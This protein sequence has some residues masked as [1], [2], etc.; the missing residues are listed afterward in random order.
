[1]TAHLLALTIGPVQEFISAARRTRDLWFGS[2]L[3]SEI[4][5]A[6]AKAV[7]GEGGALIFPA[8]LSDGELNPDSELNVANVIVSELRAGL[9]PVAVAQTAKNAAHER[10]RSFA[11]PVFETHQAFI[12]PDIWRDQVDDVIE[13]YAAWVHRSP[14]GYQVDRGRLMRLLAGR[15]RCRDFLPAKGRAGVPKSSLDGLRETV[16]RPPERWPKGSRYRPRLQQ[17]EQLDVVAMVKRTWTPSTGSP[18][19][20]SVGRVAADPWLRG[21]GP[22]RLQP[23]LEA[24]EAL[25]NNVLHA[26]DISAERGHDHYGSFPFEGTAVYGSRHR[27]LQQEAGL[28]SRD[29][30]PLA[31]AVSLLTRDFGEPSPYLAVLVADGDRIGRALSHLDSAEKHRSFSQAL[32]TFARQARDVVHQHRGILVYAG[33]DD[34][35]AV[36]PADQCLACAHGLHNSFG[37][38]LKPAGVAKA[39]LCVGVAIAHFMEP[40]EDLLEYGRAAEKHAKEPRVEDGKQEA[41]NALAV[42]VIKRG[43]GPVAIRSNWHLDPNKRLQLQTLA[44]WIAVRAVSGRV[45]YDLR[46]IAVVYDTWPAE[47]V[48]AAIQRDTLATLQRKQP[49]GESRMREVGEFI[50]ARVKG[51]DS[52][53]R[54][55]D[56]LLVARQI[57]VAIGQAESRATVGED[58]A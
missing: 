50:R 6:T 11:D 22:E 31:R 5:K 48:E 58:I 49:L 30:A 28:S 57:A 21:V 37:N 53:R 1:M 44:E 55:S 40:L 24:S 43:G 41:R 8:P 56:E 27:A 32:A 51:A 45:A 23:V 42:H 15:K 18:Q 7:L 39:T 36:I 17:G 26:L 3:L 33:G 52:L 2:Y 4:S 35:V 13:F 9:N 29:L 38:A 14:N 19:Y 10:W 20:P 54:L 34:V 47:S 46:K 16:L 25:G 12:T